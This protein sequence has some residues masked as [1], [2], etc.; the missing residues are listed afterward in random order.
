M[1]TLKKILH[2]TKKANTSS[3][4]ITQYNFTDAPKMRQIVLTTV[5]LTFTSLN[6]SSA[7]G[8][9]QYIGLG[10]STLD[11]GYFR[12]HTT[13]IA[14]YDQA[15]ATALAAGAKGGFAG[16]GVMASTILAGRFGLNAAP[17]GGGGSNY[18]NGGA[19]TLATGPLLGNV[20]TVQEIKNYLSDVN[21]IANPDALYA[22]SSGNNDLTFVTSQGSAADPNYLHQQAS[23][24]AAEVAALQT[25]GAHTILVP[26]FFQYAVLAS[27]GGNIANSD[28]ATYTR[29]VSYGA[30]IW[31]SLETAGV[32]FIPADLDS[33]FKYVVKNPTLFGFTASS[34]LA[35]N[36]PASGSSALL[37]I[38]TPAQQQDYLFID[39]KHLTTAG[40]QIEADYEY[41]LLAAP[42]QVSLMAE[43]IVQGGLARTAT[44]QGQIELSEQHRG[45]NGINV[46]GSFG[47]NALKVK[48]ASG[49]PV[50]SGAPF[51]GTVGVDYR[52]PGGIILGAAFTGGS[53]N[54]EFSTGG[55]YDQ[56]DETP[57]LYAAYKTGAVW[58]NAVASYG[59]FQDNIARQVTLGTFVDQ[60][61]ADTTGQSPALALRGGGDFKLSQITTGPVAGL[62]L[63]QIHVNGFTETGA[64]SVTALSF[65]NQTRDSLITQLGWRVL[66]DLGNWQ[67]FAEVKW[68]H[69][70]ASKDRVVTASLTS[71]AAPSY[72]VAAAPVASDWANAFLGTSY[73]LNSQITL[74]GVFSGVFLN[75]QVISYGGELGL[76]VSF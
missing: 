74:R 69:E 43:G 36:A 63:Q 1:Q 26:N 72:S 62:V 50:A 22:I 65:G 39:G 6:T 49:F 52:T 54:Q 57:S 28:V 32:R 48:N 12:Y 7:N 41:S 23:A 33:V 42:S 14:S 45:P 16:N 4:N 59:F 53:R 27:Y 47:S 15:L 70:L 5:L 56:V 30:D 31:S 29:S 40:Q 46:W 13:G 66:A 21:G 68:N 8:F 73:K 76:N 17:V 37:A 2:Q 58:G 44:I 64:S 67:P 75:P 25:A 60:N 11:S 35:S 20:S 71:V 61:H 18:A 19:Y 24:L 55:Y 9:N 34:V 10:D 3:K 51:G 38:L